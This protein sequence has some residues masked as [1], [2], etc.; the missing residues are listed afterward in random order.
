M[1]AD[2]SLMERLRRDLVRFMACQDILNVSYGS[3]LGYEDGLDGDKPLTR[4]QREQYWRMV[5]ETEGLREVVNSDARELLDRITALDL[6]DRILHL[7]D[8]TG[9]V[10]WLEGWA[11]PQEAFD[12][13]NY[14]D[15]RPVSPGVLVEP[16]QTKGFEPGSVAV[17]VGYPTVGY[18]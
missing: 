3:V 10:V 4:E 12:F 2:A 8:T 5:Q 13:Y 18:Q 1:S 15:L 6:A 16:T 14:V 11:E 9:V 17:Q 7:D